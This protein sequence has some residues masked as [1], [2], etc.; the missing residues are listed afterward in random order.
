MNPK[1]RL[2]SLSDPDILEWVDKNYLITNSLELNLISKRGV[3]AVERHRE[4]QEDRGDEDAIVMVCTWCGLL[5][6]G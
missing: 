1:E 4:N 6:G 2:G 5:V 3:F